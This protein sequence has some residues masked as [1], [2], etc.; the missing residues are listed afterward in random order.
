MLEIIAP[1]ALIVLFVLIGV[2]PKTRILERSGLWSVLGAMFALAQ[3]LSSGGVSPTAVGGY[4]LCGGVG[5]V[6]LY[7]SQ[8]PAHAVRVPYPVLWG[9]AAVHAVLTGY[10]LISA[11]SYTAAMLLIASVSYG[12][13]LY[14]S[15]K[16][17]G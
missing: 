17:C 3:M 16:T 6:F 14:K 8:S 13:G 4:L 12:I 1:L 10:L 5:A 15:T 11:F 2:L 9:M 7:V